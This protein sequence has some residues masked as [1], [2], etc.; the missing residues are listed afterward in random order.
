MGQ[1]A[2][3]Q[4][5]GFAEQRRLSQVVIVAAMKIFLPSMSVIRPWAVSG[6]SIGVMLR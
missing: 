3:H 4:A 5:V 2:D 6:S 1:Q